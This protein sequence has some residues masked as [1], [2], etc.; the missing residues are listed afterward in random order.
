[1]DT[2]IEKQIV[3]LLSERPKEAI[4][5]IYNHYGSSLYGMINAMLGNEAEAQDVLQESFIKYWR[6][7]DK[8]DAEKAKLYTWLLRIARNTALDKLRS[9]GRKAKHEIRMPFTDVCNESDLGISPDL[10]DMRKQLG[11]LDIK[12]QEVLQALYFEG[13]TQQEASETLNLP[14]G[15]IK[16]RL[17][18]AIR[19][20]RSIFEVSATIFLI[21]FQ[22]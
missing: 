5:L 7:A 18:I 19:E 20:L 17:R 10:V 8:Y 15:T 6:N 11:T 22:F 16:S 13:M 4:P 14:L 21:L 3:N 1:V 9:K 12:Y 2:S